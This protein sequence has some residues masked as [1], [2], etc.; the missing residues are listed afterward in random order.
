MDM[1]LDSRLLKTLKKDE[2]QMVIASKTNKKHRTMEQINAIIDFISSMKFFK[3]FINQPELLL[4]IAQV[5][6]FQGKV[7]VYYNHN[8]YF[9]FFI[10]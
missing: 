7:Y 4:K 6:D 2:D 8:K 3:P 9:L 5:I 10:F 1:N